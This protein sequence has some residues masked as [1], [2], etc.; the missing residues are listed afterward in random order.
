MKNKIMGFGE[1]LEAVYLTQRY[2]RKD[3]TLTKQEIKTAK[4]FIKKIK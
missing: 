2:R 4:K 3:P 1:W